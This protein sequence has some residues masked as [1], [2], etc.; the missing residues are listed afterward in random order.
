MTWLSEELEKLARDVSVREE[1]PVIIDPEP[2]LAYRW[3]I[4]TL[5]ICRKA[6]FKTVKFAAAK[7]ATPP[8]DAAKT[9]G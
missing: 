9:P 6:R 7:P 5:N 4:Q 3:V 2:R 1:V 8:A